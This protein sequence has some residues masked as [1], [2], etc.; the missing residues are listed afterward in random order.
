[1]FKGF[2]ELLLITMKEWK[3][4]L[5]ELYIKKREVSTPE[6]MKSLNKSRQ[7]VNQL[8]YFCVQMYYVV[9]R[10]QLVPG[11]AGIKKVS[12]PTNFWSL[13]PKNET[14]TKFV[15]DRMAEEESE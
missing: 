6:L 15:L 5:K 8:G 2:S 13:N 7:S 4:L 1:L 3:K 10:K 12:R 9:R 14:R 11:M